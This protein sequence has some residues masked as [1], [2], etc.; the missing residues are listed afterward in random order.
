MKHSNRDRR[1]TVAGAARVACVLLVLASAVVPFRS[2][3]PRPDRIS[4]EILAHRAMKTRPPGL[5]PERHRERLIALGLDPDAPDSERCALYT[6]A[7]LSV[8]EIELL[9]REGFSFEGRVWVPP[10]P[11]RH[12]H[13][14]HLVRVPYANLELIASDSRFVRLMSTE[15]SAAPL[16]NLARQKVRV[17]E[18]HQ[19]DGI[20]PR[21]GLGVGIAI[22][23]SGLD[24]THPD[25]PVPFE[26]YDVTD[27]GDVST[28]GTDVTNTVIEHGTHVT[29]IALASGVS[30]LA[31]VGN[32]GGDYRGA[33]PAASLYFYKIG[34]DS[35]GGTTFD[36]MIEAVQRAQSA[37]ADIF[38]MSYGGFS[39]DFLDGSS[40]VCQAI[41][42]AA[43]AG[44]T[45]FISAGN[46]ARLDKH[47]S[48]RV[49]PGETAVVSFT[50]DNSTRDTPWTSQETLRVL[51]LDEEPDDANVT[52][53]VP[54]LAEGESLVPLASSTSPRGTE[55]QLY[56]LHP[57]VPAL[58]IRSYE[59]HLTNA[60]LQGVSPLVHAYRIAGR[61][62][63][64]D[65]DPFYTL[66][67]PAICDRAITVGAWTHREQW[68]DYS[69]AVWGCCQT[70]DTLATFSSRGPRIDGLSKPEIVA[71]G[72]TMISLRD[73]AFANFPTLIID[74]DGLG[75]DGSG[76][77]HYYAFSGTSMA[78]PMAAGSAALLVESRPDITPSGILNALSFSAANAA[79]PD[80][81]AGYGLID[82]VAALQI[83]PT[84]A[85]DGDGD[86]VAG[87]AG[88][89]DDCD[90]ADSDV[91]SVPGE[92]RDLRFADTVTL[93]WRV[94]QA[95]GASAVSYDTIRSGNPA[96]FASDGLCLESGD[97]SDHKAADPAL[98]APGTV[99]YYLVRALNGCPAGIGSL[100]TTSGNTDRSGPACP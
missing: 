89:D 55:T 29:G 39:S 26:A 86:A 31:N 41:D 45:V 11:G 68:T 60:A 19:G 5:S 1:S 90:D 67:H 34:N 36:D 87:P 62:K 13:G 21:T 27:G 77:A 99:F 59:L 78:A 81:S 54:G 15:R 3:A 30:S 8:A 46:N 100:G 93:T 61:G 12:R 10:V 25:L 95:P 6:D 71:P 50:I 24:T 58:S 84:A 97:S 69:N 42:A 28:W 53:A 72:S 40:P 33:A 73:G 57:V 37:G 83:L 52:L 74:D 94:P 47:D 70:E 85:V 4:S 76:P 7:P 64:D 23:D 16:N 80:D 92:A 91:W 82:A 43:A 35:S 22:A 65:A 88:A 63:F 9:E 32:G 56:A 18:V 44:L 38:S 79:Q 17:D 20:T 75:L 51:W 96:D 2:A 66:S 48:V 14:F 49:A 98:P